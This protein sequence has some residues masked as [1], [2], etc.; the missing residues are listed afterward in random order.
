[1]MANKSIIRELLISGATAC[2]SVGPPAPA[3]RLA[4]LSL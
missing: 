4:L 3:F 1:M 2:N